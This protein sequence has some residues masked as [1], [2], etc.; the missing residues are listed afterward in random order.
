MV[1]DAELIVVSYGTV[2]RS[3]RSA[4]RKAREMGIKA[5]FCR[6]ISIW[7]FPDS[8]IQSICKNA[9]KII[10]AEM[11]LGM[12]KREVERSTGRSADIVL[13]AKPGVELHKPGGNTGSDQKDDLRI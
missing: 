1:E 11:N 9:K 12:V 5:G 4:V 7:P 2:S 8:A 6:L 13:L 3:A 10:V